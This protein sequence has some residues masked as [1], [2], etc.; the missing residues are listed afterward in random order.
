MVAD[1][2][3]SPTSEHDQP[4]QGLTDDQ[5]TQLKTHIAELKFSNEL[6]KYDHQKYVDA[7]LEK[8][9]LSFDKI[10][11]R[12][13]FYEHVAEI[14]ASIL[15]DVPKDKREPIMRAIEEI[16]NEP[17]HGRGRAEK[18][19][20]IKRVQKTVEAY[21]QEKIN[22]RFL[23]EE[24]MHNA[25]SLEVAR[26]LSEDVF[27]EVD[28]VFPDSFW[29]LADEMSPQDFPNFAAT[30]NFTLRETFS[31]EESEEVVKDFSEKLRES[32][33]LDA[34]EM[35]SGFF[36][37]EEQEKRLKILESLGL[38]KLAIMLKFLI[39]LR[40]ERKN[41]QEKAKKLMA[42]AQS[43][44]FERD[45]RGADSAIAEMK[46]E[47]GEEVV[48]SLNEGKFVTKLNLVLIHIGR[49]ERQLE[50]E[51]N[52]TRR[53]K[54]IAEL[55]ELQVENDFSN[56][57]GEEDSD[58]REKEIENIVNEAREFKEQG[59]FR[60]AELSLRRLKRLDP[61]RAEKEISAIRAEQSAKKEETKK[62]GTENV[63]EEKE[64]KIEFLEKCIEHAEAIKEVCSELGIPTDDPDFW[65]LEGVRGRVQWLV[66]NHKWSDYRRFN[67]SDR[68]MP[69][70]EYA[71]GFRFRWLDL[72][73]GT[74]LTYSA[75]ESGIEYL[76]RYKESGYEVAALAGAFSVDWKGSSSPVY[77]P[78]E[79]ISITNKELGDLRGVSVEEM[80]HG[81]SES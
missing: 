72:K 46:E 57:E 25:A 55:S 1:K 11:E 63:S 78:D 80:K 31:H 2:Y 12:I 45:A 76:A 21:K 14:R 8:K 6:D 30:F 71:G 17:T 18:L 77:T 7:H 34:E 79:F 33:L 20:K 41:R 4:G 81:K 16:T 60:A 65:G 36:S 67:E 59:D 42:L 40:K 49:V 47:F 54:L 38:D 10:K 27:K 51:K 69:S 52:K 39:S 68:N 29:R 61:V 58:E 32:A 53:K 50:S 3:A 56:E 74:N 70:K 44:F 43:L 37:E 22:I 73:T 75:A 26:I 66:D 19:E 24:T 28:K 62:E 35:L 15:Q 9:D 5:V 13:D 23:L 64:I 48:A